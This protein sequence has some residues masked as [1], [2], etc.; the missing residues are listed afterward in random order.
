[1]TAPAV[2]PARRPENAGVTRHAPVAL[3]DVAPIVAAVDG[4]AASAAAVES[5]V[6]LAGELDAPIV[7]VYVRRGPA[8]FLGTPV[9]QR[10]LTAKLARGRHVLDHAVS[11]AGAAG[12]NAE[13]EIL[14]GRARRRIV[15][16]ARDRGAR[17]LV[18]GSRRHKVGRGVSCAVVRTAEQPVVVA[19]GLQRLEV[20]GKAVR[21][22]APRLMSPNRTR[23]VLDTDAHGPRRPSPGSGRRGPRSLPPN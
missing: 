13:G 4:T 22:R 17:L 19:K 8:G 2:A 14:E 9:Y 7:F 1:M 10:R 3:R 20:A 16:F 23:C 6:T 12:I 15:E 5:A 21:A 11:V 18:V